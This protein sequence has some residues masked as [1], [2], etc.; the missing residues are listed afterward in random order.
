[1][2]SRIKGEATLN[3]RYGTALLL[4]CVLGMVASLAQAQEEAAATVSTTAG[5]AVVQKADGSV[6]ALAPGAALHAGDVIT[7]QPNSSALI[8]FTDGGEL[9]VRPNSQ[10][11]LDAYHY[12]PVL[13][14]ADS[15]V[16]S[17]LKGGLRSITG[18]ISRRGP[19]EAY[20]LQTATATIGI[21]GTDF[22]ARLCEADECAKEAAVKPVA[23]L[24]PAALAIAARVALL[25]GEAVASDPRGELRGL[26]VG[27]PIYPGDTVETREKSYAVLVFLDEGRVTLQPGARLA[28]ERFRYEPARPEAGLSVLRLLRGGARALTGVLARRQPQNYRLETV[29]ATIGIRGTGFDAWCGGPCVSGEEEPAKAGAPA[30]SSAAAGDGLYASTWE[31]TI[32]VR[33]PAGVQVVGINQTVLVTAPDQV[34]VFIPKTPAFMREAPGPRPDGIKVDMQQLFGGGREGQAD[35]GLYVLVNDG[36]IVLMQDGRLLELVRGESGY[37]SPDGAELYR[38][39]FPPVF[40]QRDPVLTATGAGGVFCGFGFQ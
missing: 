16:M 32:D 10:V 8:K 24:R 3:F 40:L 25:S 11:K 5:T 12:N 13:P 6:R 22:M 30:P 39:Q 34:P 2:E 14:K 26:T 17:L 18:F 1:V 19:A 38:L 4:G 28:V 35:P 36:A 27:S 9:T 21:R 15:L 29:V 7:T 33:N 23:G 31:G 20:R 37:A